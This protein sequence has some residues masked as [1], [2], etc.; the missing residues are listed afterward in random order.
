MARGDW[1][2]QQGKCSAPP[3]LLLPPSLSFHLSSSPS[4]PF[5]LP[6]HAILTL[7]EGMESTRD[8]PSLVNNDLRLGEE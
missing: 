8:A 1:V 5:F 7:T 3:S 2:R 6:S 4:L